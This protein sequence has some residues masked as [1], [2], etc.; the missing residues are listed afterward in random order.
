MLFVLLHHQSSLNTHPGEYA[1][2]PL[3]LLLGMASGLLSSTL[4]VLVGALI[5]T[6]PTSWFAL[7]NSSFTL[8]G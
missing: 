6:S 4:E 5:I 2:H 3:E 8:A 7:M 1:E